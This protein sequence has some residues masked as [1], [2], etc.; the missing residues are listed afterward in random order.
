MA[1]VLSFS[2][3]VISNFYVVGYKL[4]QIIFILVFVLNFATILFVVLYER[5]A[6]TIKKMQTGNLLI[7]RHN[8]V[9]PKNYH[10]ID[11]SQILK[12]SIEANGEFLGQDW[13][14]EH[15]I[16]ERTQN[17]AQYFSHLDSA[18]ATNKDIINEYEKKVLNNNISLA[19]THMLHHQ[20]AI[21]EMFLALYFRPNNFYCIHVDIKS[22]DLIRTVV[23]NLVHCY[24]NKITTGKIFL[25][26]KKN[27]LD[28]SKTSMHLKIRNVFIF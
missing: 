26:D 14:D 7:G 23:E 9:E 2:S 6:R 17:C 21:Y 4:K 22:S 27:S 19:F 18:F 12:D 11:I 20:V 1:R 13:H 15:Q 16:L 5:N 3:L 24:S 8:H 28:V 10:I 25:L